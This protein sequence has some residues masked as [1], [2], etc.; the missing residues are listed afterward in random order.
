[1]LSRVHTRISRACPQTMR[2]VYPAGSLPGRKL[3]AHSAPRTLVY[4]QSPRAR[5]AISSSSRWMGRAAPATP[6]GGAG[7]ADAGDPAPDRASVMAT[8][9]FSA[10][11]DAAPPAAW[12]GTGAL[13][14]PPVTGFTA[15][16]PAAVLPP[17]AGSTVSDAPISFPPFHSYHPNPALVSLPPQT[18][19]NFFRTE[20]TQTRLNFFRTERIWRS[21]GKRS[22]RKGDEGVKGVKAEAGRAAL[23]RV[24]AQPAAIS[25]NCAAPVLPV[26]PAWPCSRRAF[27]AAFQKNSARASGRLA[28]FWGI[29]WRRLPLSDAPANGSGAHGGCRAESVAPCSLECVPGVFEA[30]SRLRTRSPHSPP[31][32]RHEAWRWRGRL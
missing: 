12:T 1:V 19:L 14:P 20:K 31:S 10:A 29:E 15:V 17:A 6:A 3:P 9:P 8:L 7:A 28:L 5:S 24:R 4:R 21:R 18:R 25:R 11:A 30:V 26:K 22:G 27:L 23:A 2:Q 16:S 13:A 32:R